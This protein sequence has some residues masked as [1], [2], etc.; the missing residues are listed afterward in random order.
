MTKILFDCFHFFCFFV[1]VFIVI[2]FGFGFFSV[3]VLFLFVLFCF[4]AIVTNDT[5]VASLVT[6][7]ISYLAIEFIPMG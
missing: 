4:L 2:D 6:A 1:F 7:G 5:V 3:F